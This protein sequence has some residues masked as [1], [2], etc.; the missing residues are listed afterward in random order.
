MG[1]VSGAIG[2]FLFWGFTFVGKGRL[3]PAWSVQKHVLLKR[4]NVHSSLKTQPNCVTF[5]LKMLQIMRR[6]HCRIV[7][8]CR[9][10]IGAAVRGAVILTGAAARGGVRSSSNLGI[11]RG[12]V[13]TAQSCMRTAYKSPTAAAAPVFSARRR[14]WQGSRGAIVAKVVPHGGAVAGYLFAKFQLARGPGGGATAL[15]S[16]CARQN[17]SG[18]VTVSWFDFAPGFHCKNG[19]KRYFSKAAKCNRQ[20]VRSQVVLAEQTKIKAFSSS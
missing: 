14:F 9:G 17:A 6:I 2:Y 15:Q 13:R 4:L 20:P 18:S 8:R 16:R 10:W 12:M 5:F 7:R 3:D 11:R 1:G 19:F